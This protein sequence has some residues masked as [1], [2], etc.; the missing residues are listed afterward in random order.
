MMSRTAKAVAVALT[1]GGC[2]GKFKSSDFFSSLASW[3]KEFVALGQKL[4]P[5]RCAFS[6]LDD[7]R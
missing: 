1:K 7:G 6:V 3:K 4:P 2:L 5:K